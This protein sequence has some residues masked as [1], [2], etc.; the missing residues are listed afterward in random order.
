MEE[1]A[2]TENLLVNVDQGGAQPGFSTALRTFTHA[3]FVLKSRKLRTWQTDLVEFGA[4]L[5]AQLG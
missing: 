1:R 4:T 2:C 5:M 3:N